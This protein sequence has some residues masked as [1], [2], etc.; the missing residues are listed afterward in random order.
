LLLKPG[1]KAWALDVL[2]CFN[3]GVFG[4][5]GAEPLS[6][7]SAP[8][9]DVPNS[10]EDNILAQLGNTASASI[11]PTTSNS[12]S[13]LGAV[14]E[15]PVVTSSRTTSSVMRAP[16]VP[17][18]ISSTSEL[19]VEVSNLSLGPRAKPSVSTRHGKAPAAGKRKASNLKATQP[20]LPTGKLEGQEPAGR[21]FTR[22][23]TANKGGNTDK[24]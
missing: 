9:Q 20:A 10:W 24:N 11:S 16:R 23:R 3:Q 12:P 5:K 22:G 4:K 17:T 18:A 8:V 21:C 13:T 19:H 1:N 14:V 15:V 6:S 7:I 2:N